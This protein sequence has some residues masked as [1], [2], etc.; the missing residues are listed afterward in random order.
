MGAPLAIAVHSS[1][2]K[3][4]GAAATHVTQASCPRTCP[5][6]GSGCYAESG[7]QGIHTARLNR[8]TDGRRLSPVD[9][10]RAER[11]A[12][13]RL[14]PKAGEPIRFGIVGDARTPAAARER[15]RAASDWTARGGGQA[16]AYTH[17]WRTVPRREYGTISALA[18]VERPA[19]AATA[20]AQ[21][22]APA[23]VV[24][25]FPAASW[26]DAGVRWIACPS[27][28]RD[29]TC[30]RCRLCFRADQLRDLGRGIAFEAHGSGARRVRERLEKGADR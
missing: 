12:V 6:L 3:L 1:N 4:G 29:T 24:G 11:A 19:D 14:S 28:T 17:A 21:G 9:Y 26:V 20:R 30:A 10:A 15:A 22:Y 2:R 27:Q 23:L 7:P 16:W 13:A 8:A 25:R 18:S 5:L